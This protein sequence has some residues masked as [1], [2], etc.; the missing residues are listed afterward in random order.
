MIAY[1]TL[2]L[3]TSWR[4]LR[5]ISWMR[6]LSLNHL[7]RV[8]VAEIYP[9]APVRSS[10]CEFDR[11]A[12]VVL[13]DF[14]GYRPYRVRFSKRNVY[15]RDGFTCQYCGKQYPQYWLTIDHVIP[16]SKGGKNTWANVVAACGPCNHKKGGRSPAEAR[17]PLLRKPSE[18]QVEDHSALSSSVPVQWKPY[19][20]DS[21]RMWAS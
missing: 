12:V 21:T 8:L 10:S 19:I 2:L 5:V 6:A 7:G 13:K 4:P 9:D 15:I 18:P 17:M 3:D 14:H 16:K 20:E 11:P 1:R